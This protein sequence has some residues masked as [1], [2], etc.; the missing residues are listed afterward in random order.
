LKNHYQVLG[1]PS[2]ATISEIK[3]AYRNKARLYHP[4]S[5]KDP[6]TTQKFVEITE[7]YDILTDEDARRNYDFRINRR[8]FQSRSSS[9]AANQAREQKWHEYTS[10]KAEELSKCHL[11]SKPSD[12][13]C[14]CTVVMYKYQHE[15]KSGKFQRVHYFEVKIPFCQACYDTI[16]KEADKQYGW[17]V[18]EVAMLFAILIFGYLVEENLKGPLIFSLMGFY[19]LF[20]WLRRLKSQPKVDVNIEGFSRVKEYLNKGW[21]IKGEPVFN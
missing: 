12:P 6:G 16:P 11:C 9:T 13:N 19:Y 21:K 7:A 2:T 3:K 20:M 5:S 15:N 17:T 18:K 1:V 14:F 10:Q 4:D 8:G